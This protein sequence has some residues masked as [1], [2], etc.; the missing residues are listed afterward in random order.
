MIVESGTRCC[1]AIPVRCLRGQSEGHCILGSG[2][3]LG[4]HTEPLCRSVP[5]LLAV[6]ARLGIQL[7][8]PLPAPGGSFSPGLS[9]FLCWCWRGRQDAQLVKIPLLSDPLGV[10]LHE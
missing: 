5:V 7:G 3:G 6:P 1:V 4:E 10:S 2:G 9:H 8:A